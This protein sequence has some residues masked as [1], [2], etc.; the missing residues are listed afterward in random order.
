MDG[1]A[2]KIALCDND[3]SIMEQ[4]KAL[5][6]QHP[7]HDLF[8][9]TCFS[10]AREL[11]AK[12]EVYDLLITDIQKDP[13]DVNGM[14]LAS[15]MSD[16]TKI[17]FF[18]SHTLTE[19]LEMMFTHQV[20]LFLYMQKPLHPV[21]VEIDHILDKFMDRRSSTSKIIKYFPRRLVPVKLELVGR[22]EI[23]LYRDSIYYLTEKRLFFAEETIV[24][25]SA[26]IFTMNVGFDELPELFHK[27][28]FFITENGRHIV[29]FDNCMYERKLRIITLHILGD[30]SRSFQLTE[31]EMQAAYD[32]LTDFTFEGLSSIER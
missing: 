21:T 2:I 27:P 30:L 23:E 7:Q 20:A 14:V 5:I 31:K 24:T 25:T 16:K 17:V 28:P 13:E 1:T 22:R 9:V 4:T 6:E 11:L 19:V 10:T 3:P 12:E 18:T 26:G 15:K 29:N 8:E 32:Y